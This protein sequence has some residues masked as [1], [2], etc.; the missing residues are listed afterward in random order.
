MASRSRTTRRP[1]VN[2]SD[3][4]SSASRP[5]LLASQF[6]HQERVVQ[7]PG[8]GAHQRGGAVADHPVILAVQQHDPA[9]AGIAQERR[10][11]L[12]W[13]LQP[14]AVACLR[15]YVAS[16][17]VIWSASASASRFGIA[18]FSRS[19]AKY[20]VSKRLNPSTALA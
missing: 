16:W 6:G 10:H 8:D 14:L 12:R 13:E 7:R 11:A 4:A 2:G 3:A 19:A 18:S 9:G 5:M 1:P 15:K 20:C 17:R